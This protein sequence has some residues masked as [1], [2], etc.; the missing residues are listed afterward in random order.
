MVRPALEVADIFRDHGP[1]WREANRG[2]V[3][4]DQLKVMSAIERC[5]TVAL[6]G[7]VARCENDRCGHTVIAY[8]SCRNRHCPKCQGAAA[9]K[10][11]AEREAELL[12]V[13]YFH[14]VYTL[15]APLRDIAYQNKRVIYDLLMK[16]AAETT[17]TIATDPKHLGAG[18]GITAVL[19]T[20]GSALTH[21]P[22]VHMIVPGGGLSEDGS[23]WIASRP[24]FL[25][26]V[27]VLSR[28]FRGRFLAMLAKAHA[29]GR[30]RFFGEHAALADRRAFKRFLAP[31][32]RSEWVVY[33][34]DPFAGPQQVLRYLSRY[35]HRV[36]ISNR[37][38]VS[39][40][41]NGVAFRWKDYR[42]DG[43][44]R[45][46]TMTLAPHEFIRRFLMHV[47]PKG[48]H[49]IRHYGLLANGNRTENV[50]K[51]RELRALHAPSC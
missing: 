10:W 49:R 12:P 6:G 31:L 42:I 21:H 43:P 8:N 37:R 16:A 5:R 23:R 45:W 30:S 15:P 48:F 29:D 44:G 39:A 9:R 40:D 2:H 51:A 19:H 1:A 50:A 35:T 11:L 25:V 36:A 34:K 38:L 20:W 27:N 47:L 32:R 26:H 46:K 41:D 18:I 7:H 14:V 24:R 4:L 13:G 33:T 22:H 3:S 28:L 17:L